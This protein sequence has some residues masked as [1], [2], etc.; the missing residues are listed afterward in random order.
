MSPINERDV[1]AE[2]LR[3]NQQLVQAHQQIAASLA[4]MEQMYSEQLRRTEAMTR[5]TR[6]MMRQV[7]S[8]K[9]TWLIFIPVIM[10]FVILMLPEIIKLF[11]N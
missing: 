1:L 9:F 4:N 8:P 5:S 2:L 11:K 3:T 10:V 7:Q 6:K